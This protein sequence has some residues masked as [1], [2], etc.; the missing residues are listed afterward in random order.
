MITKDWRERVLNVVKWLIGYK[1][2]DS[3]CTIGSVKVVET[4]VPILTLKSDFMV[5][6]YDLLN[7][8]ITKE[9]I[10]EKLNY[11]MTM[12]IAKKL[13]EDKL[14]TVEE[15][16]NFDWDYIRY[17]YQLKILDERQ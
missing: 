4:K 17:S 15:Q 10:K 7:G 3:T 2:Y 5:N 11:D 1:D 14:V 12:S 16:Y 8:Y 6:R 9:Q 13:M